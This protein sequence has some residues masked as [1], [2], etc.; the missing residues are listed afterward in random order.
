MR[1]LIVT[2]KNVSWPRLIWPT[3]YNIRTEPRFF[4][5][6][7]TKFVKTTLCLKKRANFGKLYFRQAW[8]NF[9]NFW[10]TA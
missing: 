6:N 9:D 3:L 8:T 5:P 7:R 1:S 4:E 10:S 2:S